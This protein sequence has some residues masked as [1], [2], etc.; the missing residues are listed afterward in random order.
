M[1]VAV[2]NTVIVGVLVS[3]ITGVWVG[4]SAMRVDSG[5]GVLVGATVGVTCGRL[6]PHAERTT[7][8]ITQNQRCFMPITNQL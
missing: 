5:V 1:T 4:R 6:V 7:A 8:R 3:R 2:G